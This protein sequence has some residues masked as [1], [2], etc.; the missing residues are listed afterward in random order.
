MS[1]FCVIVSRKIFYPNF[2]GTTT[3][4]AP[5]PMPMDIFG[6]FMAHVSGRSVMD[7]T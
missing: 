6:L 3:S 7:L 1:E 5:S 2:E 4:S